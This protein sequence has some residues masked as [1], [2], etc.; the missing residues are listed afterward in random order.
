MRQ[1][2]AGVL[3]VSLGGC[4][5]NA[6]MTLNIFTRSFTQ[7]TQHTAGL[8]VLLRWITILGMLGLL[9]MLEWVLHLHLSRYVV[10]S[11]LLVCGIMALAN[12]WAS[13][14]LWSQAA[15]H[16]HA[17]LAWLC[18]DI[19]T[20]TCILYLTGGSTNPFVSLY[21]LPIALAVIVL[22]ARQAAMVTLLAASAYTALLFWHEPLHAM[23]TD[24]SLHVNGMWLNFLLSAAVL[25]TV[26]TLLVKRLQARDQQLANAR[27]AALRDQQI[28]AIGTVAAGTAHELGTPLTTLGM[29]L[30]ELPEN[31]TTTLMHQ[32]VQRCQEQLR[33]LLATQPDAV[34]AVSCSDYLQQLT[35][36]WAVLHPLVQLQ[37]QWP[38]YMQTVF[39]QPHLGLTQCIRSVL[40]N[41]AAASQA[42]E[43][44]QVGV[45]VSCSDRQTTLPVSDTQTMLQIDVLDRGA[46][47]P[48]D[49]R[50]S[51]PG[52]HG[53][54]LQLA[55]RVLAD[56]GGQLEFRPATH[57]PWRT[58]VR[59]S[60]PLAALVAG[61]APE[62]APEPAPELTIGGSAVDG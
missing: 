38:E 8:M 40:D 54:G 26:V 19:V 31:D 12:A 32:Q 50:H 56:L 61:L 43:H 37:A 59:I 33:Q 30:N 6:S 55:E 47:L 62:L 27:E 10:A 53:V 13:W 35:E 14:R 24:F 49:N 25:L 21:L 44:D 39:I 22:P 4:R 34:Q 36:H 28:V 5:Y 9:V 29:L 7:F 18:F 16:Q 3:W 23:H 60:V 41:A 2:V 20:L 42:A 45:V 17:T 57:S 46:G 52:G 15:T 51:N 1:I 11:G 48:E 58:Q